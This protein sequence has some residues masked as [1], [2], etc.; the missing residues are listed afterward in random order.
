M[1]CYNLRFR[2]RGIYSFQRKKITCPVLCD[3][4]HTVFVFIFTTEFEMYSFGIHVE[5][6]ELE[7]NYHY[8]VE[9]ERRLRKCDF[10]RSHSKLMIVLGLESQT[11]LFP[12][13]S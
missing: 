6:L 7:L 11:L 12:S 2:G 9:E 10:P 4:F 8:Y 1:I 13:L 3:R 5:M